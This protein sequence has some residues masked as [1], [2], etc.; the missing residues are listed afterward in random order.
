MGYRRSYWLAWIQHRVLLRDANPDFDASTSEFLEPM[1]FFN[2]EMN[3]VTQQLSERGVPAPSRTCTVVSLFLEDDEP[4]AAQAEDP[5]LIQDLEEGIPLRASLEATWERIDCAYFVAWVL[6]NIFVE[7]FPDATD[8]EINDTPHV[9]HM[10]I[11]G[12]ALEIVEQRL[13]GMGWQRPAPRMVDT[14][15]PMLALDL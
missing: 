4:Q 15:F 6:Q 14:L 8:D 12:R 11:R 3:S 1:A 5:I 13:I 9:Q 10:M 7:R 2:A